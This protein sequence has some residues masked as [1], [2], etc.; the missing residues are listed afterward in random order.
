MALHLKRQETDDILRILLRTPT[1]QM[2]ALLVNTPAPAESLLHNLEQAAGGKDFH[3]I[4]NKT[5]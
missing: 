5:E 3:V 4:E 1:M 2:T